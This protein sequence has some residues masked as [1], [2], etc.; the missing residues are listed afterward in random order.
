MADDRVKSSPGATPQLPQE[1]A[2]QLALALDDPAARAP[3]R[4]GLHVEGGVA[5]ERYDFHFEASGTGGVSSALSCRMTGRSPEPKH[6]TLSAKELTELLRKVDV[7]ALAEAARR[8]PR[9]PPDSLVGRLEVG[10]E[11]QR[12]TVLFMAD[13]EQARS[14]GYEPPRAVRELTAAIYDMGA[15]QLREK[16]VAP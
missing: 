5:N 12:V 10:N 4:V 1:L 9:F 6:G 16:T 3:I 14:A 15:K 13:P 8:A 7:K 11:T 2:S